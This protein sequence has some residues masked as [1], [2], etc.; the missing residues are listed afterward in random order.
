MNP[1]DAIVTGILYISFYIWTFY[2]ILTGL[3]VLIPL[4]FNFTHYIL[5][6]ITKPVVQKACKVTTY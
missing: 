4:P 5:L 6:C 2:F 3:Q 1:E